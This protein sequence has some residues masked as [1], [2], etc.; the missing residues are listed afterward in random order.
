[1]SKTDWKLDL[2]SDW[3]TEWTN[4]VPEG[5]TQFGSGTYW[6]GVILAEWQSI[7]VERSEYKDQI[8]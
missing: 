8:T 2:V 6:V 1:M 3:E 5:L 4:L 7:R